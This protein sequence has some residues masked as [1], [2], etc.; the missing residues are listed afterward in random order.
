MDK[1]AR[2]EVASYTIGNKT[3]PPRHTSASFLES[4]GSCENQGRFLLEGDE[5]DLGLEGWQRFEQT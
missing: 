4:E 2:T 1:A 3:R 5:I